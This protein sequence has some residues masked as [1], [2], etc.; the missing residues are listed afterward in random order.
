MDK[1]SKEVRS[2]NMS[3]IKSKNT[4][5]EI[6]LRKL[7]WANGLRY[8]IHYKLSGSP[9]IVFVSNRLAVFVDGCFWHKCPKCYVEPK[10]NTAFWKEKAR[11]NR[12]RDKRNERALKKS[13]WGVLRVWEHEIKKN[14]SKTVQKITKKLR[15]LKRV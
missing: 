8:R 14:P 1:I 3:K 2:H 13:G 5:P 11:K 9:D 6:L 4:K 12:E 10:S 15:G 7:L